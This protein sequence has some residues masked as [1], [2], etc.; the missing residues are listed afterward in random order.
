MAK[1]S[2]I[3]GISTPLDLFF[4]LSSKK[5]KSS[6]DERVLKTAGTHII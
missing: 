3:H 1:I 4:C 5:N 6:P 2:K